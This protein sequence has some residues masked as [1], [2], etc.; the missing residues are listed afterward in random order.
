MDE[1]ARWSAM[2]SDQQWE[3]L[4]RAARRRATERRPMDAKRALL[5]PK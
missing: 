5:Q 4:Q 1:I 2:S 3:V